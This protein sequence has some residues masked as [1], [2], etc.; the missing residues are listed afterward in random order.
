MI[1]FRDEFLFNKVNS[2]IITTYGID[3]AQRRSL[4][5]CQ[6]D[7][8]VCTRQNQLLYIIFRRGHVYSPCHI[9]LEVHHNEDAQQTFITRQLLPVITEILDIVNYPAGLL[10]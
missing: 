5:I 7:N 10:T 3:F 1:D 8:F 6:V 4:I 9:M 2:P